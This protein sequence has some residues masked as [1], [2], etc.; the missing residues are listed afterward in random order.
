[1]PDDYIRQWGDPD[2]YERAAVV[3]VFD[4]L[5]RR[6]AARLCRRLVAADGA[7]LAATQVGLLR[8]MFA[9]RMH[10]DDEAQVLVNPVVVERSQELTTFYE[11]CLSFNTI[12]VAVTRPVAV[13][14]TARDVDGNPVE[15]ECRDFAASL[16]QHEIDHLDGILTLHRAA[17]QERRRATQR[18]LETAAGIEPL[19]A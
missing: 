2:L 6:Q 13:R 14:V 15:L 11:G 7:G 1:M 16:M 4:D 12:G 3:E 5:L 8:R 19:A 18:L 10:P 9:F 17:P